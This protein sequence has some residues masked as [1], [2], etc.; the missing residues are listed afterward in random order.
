LR[1]MECGGTKKYWPP[2]H[3][4]IQYTSRSLLI[5]NNL[6]TGSAPLPYHLLRG[7][8]FRHL[9]DTTI[10]V[11]LWSRESKGK[12]P[13]MPIGNPN[14]EVTWVGRLSVAPPEYHNQVVQIPWVS[15]VH[16]SSLRQNAGDRLVLHEEH[17]PR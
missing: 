7:C 4:A 9:T 11:R 3:C 17:E 2:R 10:A 1:V 12:A 8:P 16:S 6:L 14:H 15:K 5:I 13:R